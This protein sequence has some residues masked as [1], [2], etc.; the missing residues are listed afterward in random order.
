MVDY[1]DYLHITKMRVLN[2]VYLDKRLDIHNY[3]EKYIS[4]NEKYNEKRE[5]KFKRRKNTKTK[6]NKSK[7]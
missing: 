7:V 5:V 6:Y 3:I 4:T 2:Y 1:V